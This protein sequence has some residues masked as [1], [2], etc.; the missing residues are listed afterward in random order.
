VRKNTI[1]IL[2]LCLAWHR[3]SIAKEKTIKLSDNLSIYLQESSLNSATYFR[4]PVDKINLAS[5]CLINNNPVFGTDMEVPKT[6][7]DCA[8]AIVSGKRI[9]LDVSYMDDT[10]LAMCGAESFKIGNKN[11]NYVINARLSDGAGTYVVQWH[12]WDMSSK[13]TII[14]NDLQIL[15]SL[16]QL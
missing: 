2:C 13:R 11:N 12:V 3:L 16:F 10:N 5:I 9:N 7:L 15:I 14:S 6:K 8:Y 4:R 1:I